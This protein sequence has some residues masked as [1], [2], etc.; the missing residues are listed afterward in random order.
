M[1]TTAIIITAI[2]C[3]TLAFISCQGRKNSEAK[4]SRK[5]EELEENKKE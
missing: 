1:N 2:I 5:R 4:D 3:L